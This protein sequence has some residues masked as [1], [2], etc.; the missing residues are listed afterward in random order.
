M[1][2]L[3]LLLSAYGHPRLAVDA[4][5]RVRWPARAGV[6]EGTR[7]Y[8][9]GRELERL[10]QEREAIAAHRAAAASQ[11]TAFNDEGPKVGPA[12]A[13]RLADLGQSTAR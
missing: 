3:A 7:Q 10:G 12:A 6:G 8:Y 2:N 11:A 1:A 13:D 4:W 5:R 9:L